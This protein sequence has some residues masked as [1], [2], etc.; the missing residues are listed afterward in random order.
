MPNDILGNL[1]EVR[2]A[3]ERDSVMYWLVTAAIDRF[4]QFSAKE[5][6]EDISKA[7]EFI[8]REMRALP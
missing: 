5:V 1:Q 3:F 8:S 6:A 7:E 2:R 4:L